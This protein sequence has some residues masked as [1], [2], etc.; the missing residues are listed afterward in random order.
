MRKTGWK[1]RYP[2]LLKNDTVCAAPETGLLDGKTAALSVQLPIGFD[3][4]RDHLARFSPASVTRLLLTV[5]QMP[6]SRLACER[7]PHCRT[8][9]THAQENIRALL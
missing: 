7:L 8:H 4:S 5:V 2:P 9:K 3:Y 6:E 1:P